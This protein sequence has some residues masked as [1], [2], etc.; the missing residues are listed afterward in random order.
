MSTQSRIG[1]SEVATEICQ[2]L[3]WA[4][5]AGFYAQSYP[6]HPTTE[7]PSYT[8]LFMSRK[9]NAIACTNLELA[10]EAW[11]ESF[12][13][14]QCPPL[15]GEPEPT[16]PTCDHCDQPAKY[17]VTTAQV[18]AFISDRTQEDSMH[19]DQFP[20]MGKQ[21]FCKAHHTQFIQGTLP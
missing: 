7:A 8:A 4:L 10:Y 18:T 16:L 14:R 21:H 13:Q 3:T 19:I 6:G 17:T 15:E 5:L 1:D 2:H 12:P 20:G 9:F 11:N